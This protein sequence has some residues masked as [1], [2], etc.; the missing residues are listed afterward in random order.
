[1]ISRKSIKKPLDGLQGL[2]RGFSVA[3]G[4]H[5]VPVVVAAPFIVDVAFHDPSSFQP[6]FQAR[7]SLEGDFIGTSDFLPA[8]I[9][10]LDCENFDATLG[11][12]HAHPA[13][14]GRSELLQS[15][16]QGGDGQVGDSHGRFLVR[17]IMYLI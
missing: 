14:L 2:S 16:R 4:T 15:N 8:A 5:E 17:F 6:T 3:V 9:A 7:E 13:T 1:M 11:G 12:N 10:S